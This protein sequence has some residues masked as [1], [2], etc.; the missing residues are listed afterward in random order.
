MKNNTFV[1]Y[2]IFSNRQLWCNS[3]SETDTEKTDCSESDVEF[4][5]KRTELPKSTKPL[6]SKKRR[7]KHTLITPKLVCVMDSRKV[8]DR[9]AVHI[10]IAVVEALGENVDDSIINRTSIQ[11]C[12]KIL[13]EERVGILKDQFKECDLQ[14]MVLHRDGKLLPNL[15]DKKIIDRLSIVINNG[16]VEKILAVPVLEHGTAE[17]QVS[18]ILETLTDWNLNN[19][20]KTLSFDTTAVNNG[21]LVILYCISQTCILLERHLG[22]KL[23]Y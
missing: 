3:L 14:A 13:R 21:Q 19:S 2:Y 17:A 8:S 23:L 11:R 20:V 4:S 10:F 5:G 15:I 16:H 18:I 1:L 6:S 22:K 7:G 9:A 12:R